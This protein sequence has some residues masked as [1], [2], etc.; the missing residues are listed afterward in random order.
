MLRKNQLQVF[1]PPFTMVSP[2]V[3]WVKDTELVCEILSDLQMGSTK[4]KLGIIFII[5]N[6]RNIE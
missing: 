5:T 3:K 4:W 1:S 6:V 2:S